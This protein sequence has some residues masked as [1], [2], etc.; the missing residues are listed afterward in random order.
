MEFRADAIMCAG[1]ADQPDVAIRRKAVLAALQASETIKQ[2]EVQDV[3]LKARFRVGLEA[4]NVYVGHAG[5]GGQ[6]VFSIVGNCA[7]TASRIEGLNKYIG[8]QTLASKAVVDGLENLLLRPLGR[9]IFVGKS[10]PLSIVEILATRSDS[11]EAQ[12]QLCARFAE[13]LDEFHREQWPM[14][15]QR[16]ESILS[17]YPNDGPS[18]FFLARCEQYRIG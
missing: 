12:A 14:A 18:R 3:M 17:D 8:T 9:F 6:F 10:E 1:T 7:N 2:F 11:N 5:G 16:F 13:G 15:V 4:G